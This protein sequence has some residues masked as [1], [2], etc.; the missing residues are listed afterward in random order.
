MKLSGRVQY[1]ED[2]TEDSFDYYMGRVCCQFETGVSLSSL[3]MAKHSY[4][5]IEPASL[6][7]AG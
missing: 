4:L 3:L 7:S 5:L 2:G 1:I 6:L